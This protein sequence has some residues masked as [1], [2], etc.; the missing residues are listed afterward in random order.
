[1]GL[2][3]A[4]VRAGAGLLGMAPSILWG[5]PV[6]AGALGP[7]LL[8]PPVGTAVLRMGLGLAPALAPLVMQMTTGGRILTALFAAAIVANIGWAAPASAA[9][10]SVSTTPN[11]TPLVHLAQGYYYG[12]R[13]YGGYYYGYR[14]PCPYRY[15]WECWF[16]PYGR[17]SCGCQPD[18]GLHYGIY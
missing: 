9:P 2:A 3:P 8:R 14:P 11:A 4:M 15:H 7:L 10:V 16:D 6:V 1:M 12:N 5:R 13:Y 18:F 17:Q